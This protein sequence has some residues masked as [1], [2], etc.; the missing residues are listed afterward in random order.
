MPDTPEAQRPETIL[1]FDFGLRRIGIAVGQEITGSASPVCTIGNGASGPDHERIVQLLDEWRPARLIVGMPA[2][3][4]GSPSEL[5]TPVRAFI[6]DLG[7]YKLPVV[8]V[9]ERYTSLEAEAVLKQS[10][11]AG[12]R[13][14]IKKAEIDSA[15][16]VLIA[17]RYLAAC[18]NCQ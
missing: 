2:H 3:S 1:A 11:A 8:A 6:A 14:R 10:R 9:D 18:R 16:A 7:R 13:G 15:A 4:D 17:E 5:Q 12:R